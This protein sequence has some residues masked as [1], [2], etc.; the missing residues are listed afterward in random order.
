MR[1]SLNGKWRLT[2]PQNSVSVQADVPGNIELDLFRHGLE[3]EPFYGE[4]SKAYRKYACHDWLYERTFTTPDGFTGHVTLAFDAIDCFA[5]IVLNGEKIGSTDN[6]FIPWKFDVT[7]KA[8]GE[9]N[10]LQ[11]FLHSSEKVSRSMPDE[12]AAINH[13]PEASA[14]LWLRKPAHSFGWDIAPKFNLGGIWRQV[15]L[16]KETEEATIDELWLRTG[17]ASPDMA[18]AEIYYRFHTELPYLEGLTIHISGD[19]GD[20][21][22]ESDNHVYA[23]FGHAGFR[24]PNPKLWAP[25]GYGE[26]NLYDI[27]AELRWHGRVVGQKDIRAGFRTV[28]LDRSDINVAGTGWFRFK[29]NGQPIRAVGSNWVPADAFHSQD[30]KRVVPILK[31]FTECNC[32]MIRCW[33]G[34]VYED[35]EF[36]DYCDEHG[37]LVWQD[38]MFSG[39]KYPQDAAFL[40]AVKREAEAIVRKLR[41]HTSLAIWCGDNECD[42]KYLGHRE[43]PRQNKINRVVLPEVLSRLDPTRPYLPSSPYLSDKAFEF[44]DLRNTWALTLLMPERHLWGSR[45]NFRQPFYTDCMAKFVSEM[46]WHGCPALSSLQKYISPEHLHLDHIDLLDPQM[47]HHASCPWDVSGLRGRNQIM[48]LQNDEY[49]TDPPQDFANFV[50]ASQIHQAE[51][52]KY[53]VEHYRLAQDCGGILWWNVM[54]CW[55][56]LS[57]AVVDYYFKR[58]LAFYYLARSQQPFAIICSDVAGHASNIMAVNDSSTTMK[59]TFEIKDAETGNILLQGAIDVSPRSQ[60]QLG[61]LRNVRA[62]NALWLITWTTQDGSGANHFFAGNRVMSYEW[63]KSLLPAIAKLDN[64]FSIES[65]Q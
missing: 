51:A 14:N 7:L 25:F 46:G 2:S 15:Y 55:P 26:P 36:F 39:H 32:N 50:L 41:H 3:P 47:A 31:L 8:P 44:A 52:F 12:F 24:V 59:G 11:V 48:P 6:A 1:Y 18:S 64:S 23:N 56:Q 49:F 17:S 16:E 63:Y 5:D 40:D 65:L 60:R 19:C 58:K 53:I 45:E 13:M 54:D 30:T 34:G 20:S 61:R 21:H 22:F 27:H 10:T 43:D 9:K 33:G 38:F 28:E 42:Q 4:N 35:D 37:L 29:V 57:D 62:H